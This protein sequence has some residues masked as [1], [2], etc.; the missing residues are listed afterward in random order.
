[1]SKWDDLLLRLTAVADGD[2]YHPSWRTGNE[3]APRRQGQLQ[4]IS[5]KI[6]D[7]YAQGNPRAENWDARLEQHLEAKN[8][9]LVDIDDNGSELSGGRGVEDEGT[10]FTPW[11][12]AR[13][14]EYVNGHLDRGTLVDNLRSQSLHGIDG[15]AG[16]PSDD[17]VFAFARKVFEDRESLRQRYRAGPA[18]GL[19]VVNQDELIR[20]LQGT[21]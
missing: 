15:P 21:P 3:M 1:M 8:D 10:G 9:A 17:D 16:S 5:Q 4:R 19:R 7:A 13:Y 14:A 11:A 6:D 12:A 2:G 20:R 18:P